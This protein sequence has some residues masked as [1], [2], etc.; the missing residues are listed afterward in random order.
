M[1]VTSNAN[2]GY[3][4]RRDE[5]WFTARRDMLRNPV[6]SEHALP[7]LSSSIWK[8]NLRR[9]KYISAASAQ[10]EILCNDS[11]SENFALVQ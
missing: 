11:I 9:D 10:I 3:W 7:I 8:K 5:N 6:R 2:T 1:W 4:S